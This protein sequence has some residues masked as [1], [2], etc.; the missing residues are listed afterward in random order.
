MVCCIS[1]FSVLA[2]PE[3]VT[4]A[5]QDFHTLCLGSNV[6][7]QCETDGL[8]ITS[9]PPSTR[10]STAHLGQRV[11]AT[12]CHLHTYLMLRHK[13]F[14][15]TS[16]PTCDYLV[17]MYIY[18]YT[19]KYITW[20]LHATKCRTARFETPSLGQK[21]LRSPAKVAKVTHFGDPKKTSLLDTFLV[22]RCDSHTCLFH[23]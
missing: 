9:F 8:Q 4:L 3:R 16:T 17:Y 23:V 6:A 14:S 19:Y 2:G 7:K 12:S 21:R 18:L 20:C 10:T 22:L 13:N 11:R 15:Y 5:Q 1:K